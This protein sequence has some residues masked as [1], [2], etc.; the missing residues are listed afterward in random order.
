MAQTF[1]LPE[2]ANWNLGR[3]YFHAVLTIWNE[4]CR[5]AILMT[6]VPGFCGSLAAWL[7]LSASAM[8]AFMAVR[9]T[10]ASLSLMLPP[11]TR[12]SLKPSLTT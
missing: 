6:Q 2:T 1:L 8:H 7:K 5:A 12:A 11:V 3:L 9:M 10:P 4:V